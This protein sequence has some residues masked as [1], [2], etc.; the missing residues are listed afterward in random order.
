M[1]NAIRFSR[2]L[3]TQGLQLTSYLQHAS[4]LVLLHILLQRSLLHH[5]SKAREVLHDQQRI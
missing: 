5:L 1:P 4:G 3:Y 2:T